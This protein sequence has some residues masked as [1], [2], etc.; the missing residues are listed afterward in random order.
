MLRR[1]VYLTEA[2]R[3]GLQVMAAKTGRTQSDLI[4]AAIDT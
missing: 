3:L 4:R 2:E 1:Q